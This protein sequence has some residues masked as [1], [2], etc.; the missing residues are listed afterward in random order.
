MVSLVHIN[1]AVLGREIVD[2]KSSPSALEPIDELVSNEYLH[3]GVGA[4]DISTYQGMGTCAMGKVVDSDLRVK[5][6]S[7]LSIVDASV[8]PVVIGAHIQAATYAFAD[9]QHWLLSIDIK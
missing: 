1:S 3:A 8:F 5:L 2:G 6:V 9:K 4:S 7:G